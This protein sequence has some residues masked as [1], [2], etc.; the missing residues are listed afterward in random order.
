MAATTKPYF[1]SFASI[2]PFPDDLSCLE[3]EELSLK[4]L[5]AHDKSE[6]R[7]FLNCCLTN[8]VFLL[9]LDETEQGNQ[10]LVLAHEVLELGKHIFGLS[11]E[12]KMK[13]SMLNG[14]PI[15]G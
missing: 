9:R 4:K 2:P 11:L 10:L 12:E 13:Y 6:S 14:N 1:E 3:V 15:L 8:G 7:R 5:Y